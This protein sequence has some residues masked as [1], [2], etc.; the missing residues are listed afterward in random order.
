VSFDLAG[1]STRKSIDGQQAHLNCEANDFITCSQPKLFRDSGTVG[2]LL[3][4]QF[5]AGTQ[6]SFHDTRSTHAIGHKGR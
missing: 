6:A 3:I 2:A 1:R 4:P 5:S